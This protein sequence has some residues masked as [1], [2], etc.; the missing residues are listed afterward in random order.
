MLSRGTLLNILIVLVFVGLVLLAI[1]YFIQQQAQQEKTWPSVTGQVLQSGVKWVYADDTK[2]N[3]RLWRVFVQYQY[4]VNGQTYTSNFFTHTPYQ[5]NYF[6]VEVLDVKIQG[7]LT[8]DQ[9]PDSLPKLKQVV[10]RYLPGTTVTV[11]YNPQKPSMAILE[12]E[13]GQATQW[14]FQ[15]GAGLIILAVIL[16]LFRNSL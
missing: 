11:Y 3:A 2:G 1:G 5:Q 13:T 6:P 4:S 9:I 15:I 8:A 7:G 16:F 10:D 14:L 12:R